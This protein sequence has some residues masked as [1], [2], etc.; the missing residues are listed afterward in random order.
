MSRATL[1]ILP[2]KVDCAHMMQREDA[3]AIDI[4]AAV[5]RLTSIASEL[6]ENSGIGQQYS[7]RAITMAMFMYAGIEYEDVLD[8]S[9][10]GGSGPGELRW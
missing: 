9:T 7:K 8:S 4:G 6:P 5:P 2:Y 3:F 10:Y 1:V